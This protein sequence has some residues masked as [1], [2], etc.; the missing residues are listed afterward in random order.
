MSKHM[1]DS[2]RKLQAAFGG[3]P[4]GVEQAMESLA[5]SKAMLSKTLHQL[6]RQGR[7]H[8]LGRG[9]YALAKTEKRT[10]QQAP[11]LSAIG[12]RIHATLHAEGL[13]FAITGLDVLL[14]FTHHLLVRFPHLVYVERGAAEWAK[15]T[16]RHTDL[17]CL[18]TPTPREIHIGLELTESTELVI[19]R[20][21]TD[22]YGAD[23]GVATL[24]RALVDLYF[25]STRKGYTIS[26]DEV[27]RI[28]FNV[29][30]NANVNYSRLLRWATRRGVDGELREVLADFAAYLAI[31]EVV[32]KGKREKSA[33]TAVVNAIVGVE[34]R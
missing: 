20:E 33:H 1:E 14:P 15:E 7:L 22:F 29:L 3:E 8:R 26:V 12:S 11:S 4:F 30:R 32:L 27:G 18:I 23:A 17:P 24:E 21:T 9:L 28:L 5:I 31:P 10:R 13:N 19:L 34:A 16:L 6:T 25:E 2:Y